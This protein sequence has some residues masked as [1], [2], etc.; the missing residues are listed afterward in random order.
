MTYNVFSGTLNPTHFTS[1]HE[2]GSCNFITSPAGGVAK[3]C[4]EYVCLWVCGSV[5]LSVCVSVCPTGYFRNHKR[6]FYQFLCMLPMSVARSCSDMFTIAASPLAGKGFSSPFK[7]HYRPG[8]GVR[9]HSAGKVCYLR[10]P[11]SL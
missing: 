5:R 4:D 10:L 3:Y 7:M 11:C 8:K 9:V 6:N 2:A 1:L